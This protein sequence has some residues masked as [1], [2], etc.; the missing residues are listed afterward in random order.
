VTVKTLVAA[1]DEAPLIN[2]LAYEVFTDIASKWALLIIEALGSETLRFNQLR[3]QV[4]GISHKMLS[5][6]LRTLERDGIVKRT[7]YATVPPRVDYTLTEAGHELQATVH[8]ICHWTRHNLD[9]IEAARLRFDT[10]DRPD[11]T[12]TPGAAR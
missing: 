4:H 6:T 9:H 10:P 8:G 7:P 2:I 5:Q 3:T 1:T 12:A 11:P